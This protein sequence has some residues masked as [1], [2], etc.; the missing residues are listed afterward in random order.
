VQPA[1]SNH[2]VKHPLVPGAQVIVGEHAPEASKAPF[3]NK[4]AA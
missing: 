1:A 4:E 3:R 2:P